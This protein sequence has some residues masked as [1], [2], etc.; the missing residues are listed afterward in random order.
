[1][2][3]GLVPLPTPARST[4]LLPVSGCAQRGR[5]RQPAAEA[6]G[7]AVSW[8]WACGALAALDG[9]LSVPA[10][11]RPEDLAPLG[12]GWVGEEALALGL[13]AALHA[14]DGT[15]EHTFELQY[16]TTLRS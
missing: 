13:L 5:L 3:R 11:R 4:T 16:P 8:D 6:R 14:R 10:G 2:V 12:L 9:A 7:I 15:E 1:M